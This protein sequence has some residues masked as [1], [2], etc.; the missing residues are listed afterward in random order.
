MSDFAKELIH[1]KLFD[2]MLNRF[3]LSAKDIGEAVGVSEVMISR[4]RN[5]KNDISSAKL[6]DMLNVVPS[7]ARDW[8]L[9]QTFPQANFSQIPLRSLIREASP[10]EK[11][12]VLMMIAESLQSSND[13]NPPGLIET[14]SL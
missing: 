14:F 2:E 5:G 3:G 9:S 12:E 6:I 4:F 11:A 8:Y 7:E 1:Q 13:A 10:Q